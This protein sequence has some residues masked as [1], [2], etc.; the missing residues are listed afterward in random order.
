MKARF[1]LPALADLESIL[2]HLRG[3]SPK[4]AKLVATRV[5]EI[6]ELLCRH[7]HVGARTDDPMIRRFTLRPY[8]YLVFYEVHPDEIL[9]MA[10]RHGARDPESMPGFGDGFSKKDG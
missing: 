9:I 3:T 10:I 5:A 2:D 1:T 4:G 7:P 8:P 6:A